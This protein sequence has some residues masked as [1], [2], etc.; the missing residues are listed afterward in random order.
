M[1]KKE[2]EILQ[3]SFMEALKGET[4]GL[5]KKLIRFAIFGSVFLAIAGFTTWRTLE[6]RITNQD[7][8]ITKQEEKAKFFEQVVT[9]QL[10]NIEKNQSETDVKINKLSNDIDKIKYE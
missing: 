3:D 1:T 7:N 8:R 9:Y 2:Q 4:V 6:G 5:F 10:K